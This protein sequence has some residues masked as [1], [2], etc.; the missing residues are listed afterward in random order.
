MLALRQMNSSKEL[1]GKRPPQIAK[2]NKTATK[3][4]YKSGHVA[5]KNVLTKKEHRKL[6]T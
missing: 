4:H 1:Y 6:Q 3:S 5:K 2:Q